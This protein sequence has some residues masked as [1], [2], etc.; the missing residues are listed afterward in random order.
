[1]E[2][3]VP[4]SVV[5]VGRREQVRAVVCTIRPRRVE[6]VYL[7]PSGGRALH[8]EIEW[9]RG[10]WEF[11]AGIQEGRPADRDARLER[12]VKMLRAAES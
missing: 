12:Y 6:V 9:R 3:I 5:E 10:A 2:Q 1:M 11:S 4:G 7:E 8:Q